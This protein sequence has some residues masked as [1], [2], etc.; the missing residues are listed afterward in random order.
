MGGVRNLMTQGG[1][2]QIGRKTRVKNK[3]KGNLIQM[4]G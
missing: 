2:K 4:K 3:E 1:G